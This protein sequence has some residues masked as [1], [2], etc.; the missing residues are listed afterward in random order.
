MV[1]LKTLAPNQTIVYDDIGAT[2][3]SYDTPICSRDYSS[4]IILYPAWRYSATTSKYRSQFL[5]GETT[6]ETQRKLDV[7]TYTLRNTYA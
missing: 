3:F 7:N 2:L 4:K 1:K 6:R 5:N